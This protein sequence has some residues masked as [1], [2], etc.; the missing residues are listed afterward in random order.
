MLDKQITVK[1]GPEAERRTFLELSRYDLGHW[2][3][4]FIFILEIM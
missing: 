2:F 3:Y 1:F 4:F